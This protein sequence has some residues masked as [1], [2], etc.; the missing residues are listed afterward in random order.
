[1]AK[2]SRTTSSN[3]AT[4]ESRNV[5]DGN[6]SELTDAP[7]R[8]LDEPAARSEHA[9][10]FNASAPRES[11]DATAV[12]PL[13]KIMEAPVAADEER[14]TM[15]SV[16]PAADAEPAAKP[17]AATGDSDNGPTMR[18][19]MAPAHQ[20]SAIPVDLGKPTPA[21]P[22]VSSAPAGKAPV[23][24][25]APAK[26]NTPTPAAKGP[27]AGVAKDPGA[28]AAKD[29]GTGAFGVDVTMS[30]GVDIHTAHFYPR[31]A[32][33]TIGPNGAFALPPDVMDGKD[34]AVLVEPL[35]IADFALRVDNPAMSGSIWVDK[36]QYDVADVRAGRTA[37]KGP[38]IAL[39]NQTRAVVHFGDFSFAVSRAAVPPPAKKG[40]FK[41]ENLLLL[42]CFGIATLLIVGPLAA[43]LA[44]APDRSKTHV[45]L[46]DQIKEHL[47][48]VNIVEDMKEPPK[49]E[50]K[51][52]EKKV[53]IPLAPPEQKKT[54]T[55]VVKEVKAEEKKIDDTLKDL[56]GDE[57]D[58]KRKDLVAE[59]MAAE[60]AKVDEALQ[61]LNAA[62]AS[63]LFALDDG[64]GAVNPNGAQ[65]T[66]D[67]TGELAKELG[68]S[69]GGPGKK[70]GIGGNATEKQVASGLEKDTGIGSKK[71]DIEGTA[72]AQ[73]VV[74]V[75]SSGG[76][77]EGELP[78]SV[79]KG[80]IA[81]KMGA[82]KACYQKGLQSNPDLS[83]KVKVA[84]LI[85]PTGGVLGARVDDSSLN[86]SSVEEC[87]L[88]NVKTWHFPPA[89]GG[90]STKVV[91]PFVFSSTH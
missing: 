66:A 50:D 1:M 55:D 28:V 88:N 11:D 13:V 52:D 58:E 51:A 32:L 44:S 81:T 64:T 78:K 27:G 46:E 37:L 10:V 16:V 72:K 89:K 76:E 49:E 36:Q 90:G 48:E 9:T 12:L 67:P 62:P 26:T 53:E 3:A 75:G 65:V 19:K 38:A 21:K 7:T 5:A 91:Y 77:A 69:T 42:L 59:K 82:I 8:R 74:R 86:N 41:K 57:R 56:K 54:A 24:K 14:T 23:A 68:G 45:S 22:A 70:P 73:K 4:A 30:W 35:G 31:P 85:Q 17:P 80:Y 87:I 79:V 29:K 60:T 15:L 25:S 33:V 61:A 40:G 83:G 63:K 71:V 84:F 6:A 47:V 39:T 43:S 18:V 20:S 2:K 34:L